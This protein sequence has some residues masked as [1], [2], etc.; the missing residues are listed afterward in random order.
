M[1]IIIIVGIINIIIII[2]VVVVNIIIIIIIVI[3]IIIIIII[4]IIIIII[5]ILTEYDERLQCEK[6]DISYYIQC[7]CGRK[8]CKDIPGLQAHQRFCTISDVPEL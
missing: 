4:V 6:N 1:F 3:I 2:V 8:L 5:I 7:H